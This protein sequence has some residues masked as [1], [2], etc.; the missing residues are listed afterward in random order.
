M[1]FDGEA[2]ARIGE[3]ARIGDVAIRPLEVVEDSRCPVNV[4][5]IHA[6]FLRVR[7]EIRTASEHRT[8]TMDLRQGIALADARSLRLSEV[9]PPRRTDMP[10]APLDYRLTFTLGPGD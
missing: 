8:E 7:V 10:Q 5:C 6:G 9:T 4:A 3:T 1:V 2:S